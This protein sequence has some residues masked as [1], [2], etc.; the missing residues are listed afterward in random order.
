MNAGVCMSST[1]A[2][3]RSDPLSEKLSF[4]EAHNSLEIENDA[5][6]RMYRLSLWVAVAVYVAFALPDQLLIPDV[7]PVTIVA[8]FAVAPGRATYL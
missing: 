4:D 5:V 3:F 7:A 6:R 1:Y 8:R 2:D